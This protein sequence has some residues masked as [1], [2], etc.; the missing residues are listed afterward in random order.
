MGT[1]KW[2]SERDRKAPEASEMLQRSDQPAQAPMR[3]LCLTRISQ[4]F[5]AFEA[6]LTAFHLKR[7]PTLELLHQ[8]DPSLD[9]QKKDPT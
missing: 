6:K 4:L 2:A 8:R 1:M 9:S 5:F 7:H 3:V